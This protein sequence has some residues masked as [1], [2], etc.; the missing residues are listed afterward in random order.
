L[1][2]GVLRLVFAAMHSADTL[3]EDVADLPTVCPADF[4]AAAAEGSSCG[5]SS[6]PAAAAAAAAVVVA[7]PALARSLAW[8]PR[9]RRSA[10]GLPPGSAAEGAAASPWAL[11]RG[12]EATLLPLIAE[13]AG[14]L[15]GRAL[16]HARECVIFL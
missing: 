10:N 9:P 5:D 11:L 16:R 12:H 3:L 8:P 4:T 15:R 14:L 7:A 6:T 2:A 13:F 1:Q